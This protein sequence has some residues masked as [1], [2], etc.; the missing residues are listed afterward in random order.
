MKRLFDDKE[1][2]TNEA[3]QIA[4]EFRLLI[5]NFVREKAKEYSVIDLD[6]V[7]DTTLFE[8]MVSVRLDR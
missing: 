5:R 6:Y 1:D 7:L 4:N 8:E 2:W 3:S